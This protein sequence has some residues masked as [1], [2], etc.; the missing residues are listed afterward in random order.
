[1]RFASLEAL[2]TFLNI[3][4]LGTE[5]G[6]ILNLD[7]S[8]STNLKT[9]AVI[10][11]GL[12]WEPK[13]LHHIVSV[14]DVGLLL[15][16]RLWDTLV[17]ISSKHLSSMSANL[18]SVISIILDPF[19]NSLHATS[20]RFILRD[21]MTAGLYLPE[22]CLQFLAVTRNWIS[23]TLYT[24]NCSLSGSVHVINHKLCLES[25]K[26]SWSLTAAQAS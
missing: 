10:V 1:M 25:V 17:F 23:M 15:T 5:F 24:T 2:P 26:Q 21:G 11:S 3:T 22:Q 13:F 19:R 18:G 8:S 12:S 4:S 20:A 9:L 6:D 7:L 16:K 14:M